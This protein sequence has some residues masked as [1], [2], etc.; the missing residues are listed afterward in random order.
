MRTAESQGNLA[1]TITGWTDAKL[2]DFGRKQAFTLN[3]IWEHSKEDFKSVHSSD[4]QRSYETAFYSL[5]F[6]SD[7]G[8]IRQ[9]KLLREMHFGTKEGLHFDGL[10]DAE[11]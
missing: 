4:L 10:P 2:T 11:K 6:P 1:G 7:E 5:G 9:S 8:L 3:P